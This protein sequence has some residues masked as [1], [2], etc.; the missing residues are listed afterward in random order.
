MEW[1]QRLKLLERTFQ[2]LGREVNS[3]HCVV[4]AAI[5]KRL[6]VE[7]TS[8]Q[9]YNPRQPEQEW[10]VPPVW[11]LIS[12]NLTSRTLSYCSLLQVRHSPLR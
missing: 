4:L 10:P 8:L 11:S 1:G 9:A 2:K 5:A 3:N 12:M 6:E 7:G